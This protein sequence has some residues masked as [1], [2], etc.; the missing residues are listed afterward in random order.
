MDLEE[1]FSNLC[2]TL[3]MATGS[4]RDPQVFARLVA[5]IRTGSLHTRYVQYLQEALGEALAQA[6][7]HGDTGL[8]GEAVGAD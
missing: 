5:A 7:L 1:R 4:L 6:E 8:P 3:G 2:L